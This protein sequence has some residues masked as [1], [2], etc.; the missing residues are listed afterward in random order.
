[1]I[2]SVTVTTMNVN[3]IS[4][5]RLIILKWSTEWPHWKVT[6][7]CFVT[8]HPVTL[9]WTHLGILIWR[10][11]YEVIE[12]VASWWVTTGRHNKCNF[13]TLRWPIFGRLYYEVTMNAASGKITRR[14]HFDFTW[15]LDKKHLS[16]G[17]Y[18]GILKLWLQ[19]NPKCGFFFTKFNMLK[20]TSQKSCSKDTW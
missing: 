16:R 15:E 3:V 1:M 12:T 13:V 4:F 18:N 9:Q 6:D 17:L 20:V 19:E 8:S 7:C 5:M 2:S 10:L 14:F 11:H